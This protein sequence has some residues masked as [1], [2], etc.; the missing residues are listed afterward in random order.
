MTIF[1]LAESES[2]RI[3]RA[4]PIC[5]VGG[6]VAGLLLARRLAGNGHRVIVLESGERTFDETIHSLN[7]IDDPAGTYTGALTGRFRGLGG[8]SSRWGG[9]LIPIT[10]TVTGA[11]D[12]IGQ[13]AWPKNLSALDGYSE[14]IQAMFGVVRGSF[15]SIPASGRLPFITDAAT[16]EPR[17][18]KCAPFR[19]CNLAI[20]FGHELEQSNAI[21][22]WLGATVCAFSV[23]RERMRLKAVVAQSLDGKRLEVSADEFILAAGAIEVTRLLLLLDAGAEGRVF[24]ECRALGRYFQDHIELELAEIDRSDPVRTNALFAYRFIHAIRRD[25]HLDLSEAAQRRDR[26]ASAYFFVAMDLEG[27]PLSEFKS[28]VQGLQRGEMAYAAFARLG[29]SLGTVGRV[30]LWRYGRGQL[31]VPR[32]VG[33]SLVARIEQFPAEQNRIRL[34]AQRD[35]LGVP[36]V[37][38]EWSRTTEDE[39][40]F[41]S[42]AANLGRY[43]SASGLDAICPLRWSAAVLDKNVELASRARSAA[44]PSGSTRMGTDPL[45]SVV[46]PDLRCHALPNVAIASASV[47]PTAGSANPTFTIMKLALWLA[48]SYPRVQPVYVAPVRR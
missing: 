23:D 46:G 15:E 1:R 5:I 20:L 48:E 28:I 26:V 18:A 37:R 43:W 34:S 42:A 10:S 29:R 22:I 16:L 38:L 8:S 31:Y 17:W 32:G 35:R 44:H 24:S 12:Y 47:F 7:E 4:A 6:G 2:N 40:C 27:S 13:P 33:L 9:R 36:K 21:E 41:R 11:R 30:G 25:L 39:R 19:K 14:E 45:Q 3:E